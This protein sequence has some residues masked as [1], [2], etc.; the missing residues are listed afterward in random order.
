MAYARRLTK[1]E[2][3]KSGITDITAD[4][5]VF[6]Q[7]L[8][9]PLNV[10]P[11]GY[12]TL[13]IYDFDKDGNHIPYGHTANGHYYYRQRMIG[14]HRAMWAWHNGEVP[15]GYVVDH[16]NNK[17]EN[18][19]DYHLSNLQLLTPAENTAKDRD[20]WHKYEMECKLNRPR[21]FYEDRLNNYLEQY[22]QAKLDKDAKRCH[23]LRSNIS[24][25]RAKLRYYDSHSGEIKAI[26][27]AKTADLAQQAVKRTYRARRAA[28][29]K[30]FKEELRILHG[31]YTKARDTYGADHETT[32]EAKA[33]WKRG[34][35]VSNEWIA[36]HPAV[37]IKEA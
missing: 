5:K 3:Q 31:R 22:E 13:W 35:Q 1:E 14:L 12:H 33:K 17:H 30:Q 32:I 18:L 15:Q 34:I 7:G 10:N 36:N 29:I 28:Q 26:E 4:G 6:R 21:S 23:Y 20:N 19:E 2:L 37:N 16:I 27:E 11:A 9:I 8:E 24:Q 25:Y